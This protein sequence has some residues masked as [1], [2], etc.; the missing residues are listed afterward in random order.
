MA[1]V[2]VSIAGAAASVLAGSLNV[3]RELRGRA[4]CEFSIRRPQDGSVPP[5]VGDEVEVEKDGTLLFGGRVDSVTRQTIAGDF[6][7]EFRY[8]CTDWHQVLDKRLT[9]SRTWTN[10]LAGDIVRDLAAD[11]LTGEG[12]TVGAGVQNGPTIEKFEVSYATVSEAIARLVEV[13]GYEFTITAAKALRFFAASTYPAPFEVTSAPDTNNVRQ[14]RITPTREKLANRI[15]VHLGN[16]ILDERSESFVSTG[17]FGG[18]P[19]PDPDQPTDGSRKSFSVTYPLHSVPTVLVNAV[20]QTVGIGE[21]DTGKDWYWNS[22]SRDIRQDD[23]GTALTAADELTVI[24]VGISETYVEAEDAG[25]IAAR[26]AVEGGSGRYEEMVEANDPLTRTQGQQLADQLVAVRAEI[27]FEAS[28]ETDDAIQDDVSALDVGQ[29]L[30]IER[31][32]YAADGEYL[33]R[34][35]R[36]QDIRGRD[37]LRAVVTAI[38]GPIT[39]DAVGFFK[40]LGSGGGGAAGVGTAGSVDVQVVKSYEDL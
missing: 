9:G 35:L 40:S 1:R 11:Y 25:S 12:F 15:V 33:I 24:Y 21:V 10:A 8:T 2:Q 32:G 23:A 7:L 14:L 26:A 19:D 16:Y 6:V 37:E 29:V 27:S 39:E 20:P 28:F 17:R 13:S 5:V 34:S 3:G 18:V 38:K 31:S 36:W 4:T 30:T 22:G